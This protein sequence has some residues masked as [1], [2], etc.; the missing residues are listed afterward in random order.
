MRLNMASSSGD[1]G[2]MLLRNFGFLRYARKVESSMEAL[3]QGLR[4]QVR[5]TSIIPRLHTSLGAEA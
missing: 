4:P 3:F 5:F 1:K 2:R